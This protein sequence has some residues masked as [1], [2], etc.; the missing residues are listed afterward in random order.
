MEEA[1]RWIAAG[2]DLAKGDDSVFRN[3]DAQE[4]EDAHSGG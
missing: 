2:Q 1:E 3:V 4:S